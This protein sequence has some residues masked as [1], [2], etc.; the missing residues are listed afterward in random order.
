VV[1][2]V[3][4]RPEALEA[5]GVVAGGAAARFPMNTRTKWAT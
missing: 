5:A 2:G 3:V 1:E 4:V